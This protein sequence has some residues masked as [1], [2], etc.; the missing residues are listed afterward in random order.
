M[1]HARPHT[2]QEHSRPD[3]TGLQQQ[4]PT[5]ALMGL[6]PRLTHLAIHSNPSPSQ[7]PLPAPS[8]VPHLPPIL[9]FLR[10]HSPPCA[11]LPVLPH[12]RTL[13]VGSYPHSSRFLALLLLFP[14]LT[15][16]RIFNLSTHNHHCALSC[17]PH[18]KSLQIC[19]SNT[20]LLPDCLHLFSSL[21]RLHL[22]QCTPLRALPSF[23]SVF[24]SLTH[25][26]FGRGYDPVVLPVGL[27]GHHHEM[28]A[29]AAAGVNGSSLFSSAWL[30]SDSPFWVIHSSPTS[31]FSLLSSSHPPF[32]LPTP[33]TPSSLSTCF[34]HHLTTWRPLSPI[35]FASLPSPSSLAHTL[36]RYPNLSTLALP[37]VSTTACPLR[38]SHLRS[39]LA[40]AAA[41]PALTSLSLLLEP[42]FSPNHQWGY[43]RDDWWA[44]AGMERKVRRWWGEASQ[45]MERGLFAVLKRCR[46]LKQ[47]CIQGDTLTD[48]L[49]LPDSLFLRCPQLT[50]LSLPLSRLPS[51]LLLLSRLTSLA[52]A[53]P[54]DPMPP[55]LSLPSPFALLHSLRSLALHVPSTLKRHY[56]PGDGTSWSGVLLPLCNLTSL[57][58]SHYL[59]FPPLIRHLTR[60]T[61]L[62][63][64]SLHRAQGSGVN[65]TAP[66][67]LRHGLSRLTRLEDLFFG[68]DNRC[69]SSDSACLP[70]LPRLRRLRV[71]CPDE[72]V[73]VARLI[74]AV[75]PSLEQLD[76]RA[77]YRNYTSADLCSTVRWRRNGDEWR[78]PVCEQPKV[79]QLVTSGP[80][81][82]VD[83]ALFPALEHMA[84]A[85]SR[86]VLWQVESGFSA[87][88]RFLHL[89]HAK[90]SGY[91]SDSQLTQLTALTTLVVDDADCRDFLA[92]LSCFSSLHTLRLSNITRGCSEPYLTCPPRLATL[93]ICRCDLPHL[94]YSLVKF[95][96]LTRLDLLHWRRLH[97]LPPFLSAFTSLR[98]FRVTADGPIPHVPACLKEF[99]KGKEWYEHSPCEG[100]FGD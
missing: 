52:L 23:L 95:S 96:R 6:L 75:A 51:S 8:M 4:Q 88:L 81:S 13:I 27:Q 38:P 80:A 79:L 14:A 20:P 86:Y 93:Q 85:G 59:F 70:R 58:L 29:A 76:V 19:H 28:R 18:L 36:A 47:L 57:S 3:D 26:N 12:L 71:Q 41:L 69:E 48:R 37:L 42:G 72:T 62:S 67:S 2:E 43:G 53:L 45:E 73:H 10:I 68:C 64:P 32:T 1:C 16:L 44:D 98:H 77:D 15:A 89:D 39:L 55:Q 87:N 11:P 7:S 24:S 33:I 31:P 100:S 40:A 50:A 91:G 83:M 82:N 61:S 99:L 60:L 84:L 9:T 17:P 21:T 94:P 65:N 66:C 90:L 97:S 34:T 35:W 56:P 49:K 30:P 78:A 25:F 5:L 92:C 22:F 74:A 63:L 54:E 46:G